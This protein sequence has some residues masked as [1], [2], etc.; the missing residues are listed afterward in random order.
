MRQKNKSSFIL[1]I[2]PPSPLPQNTHTPD[3]LHLPLIQ[4]I[5][6]RLT[7]SPQIWFFT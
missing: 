3:L 4:H 1:H 2:I 7:V 5:T 6:Q